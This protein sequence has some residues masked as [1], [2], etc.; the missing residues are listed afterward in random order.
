MD[1]RF[2]VLSLYNVFSNKVLKKERIAQYEMQMR[3][4]MT[5]V[6]TAVNHCLFLN[7][8]LETKRPS[9]VLTLQRSSQEFSWGGGGKEAAIE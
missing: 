5:I 4:F 9:A 6:D 2:L 8:G 1:Q 7:K 3:I